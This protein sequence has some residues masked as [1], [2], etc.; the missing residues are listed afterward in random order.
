VGRLDSA[1]SVWQSKFF[2]DWTG[3]TQRKQVRESFKQIVA[4]AKAHGVSL[5]VWILALPINLSPTERKWFDTWSS[6][7]AN[8]HGMTIELWGGTQLRHKLMR[9]DAEHLYTAYFTGTPGSHAAA[10]SVSTSDNLSEF[11]DAL[12]AN[13]C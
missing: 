2:M 6:K 11:D 10:E 8:T 1:I 7:Q 13:R 5:D 4:K 12:F 3:E 9:P